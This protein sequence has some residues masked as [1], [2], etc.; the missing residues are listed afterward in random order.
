MR[1]IGF[2]R[3]GAKTKSREGAPCLQFAL[4]NGRCYYHGG[5]CTGPKTKEGKQ[6][7]KEANTKHGYYSKESIEER[8]RFRDILNQ[9]KQEIHES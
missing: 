6:R 5:R 9:M 4:K 2:K 7:C 8:K 1:D 3:C